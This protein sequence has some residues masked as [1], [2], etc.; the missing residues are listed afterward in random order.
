[1]GWGW[2]Y[3]PYVSVGQRRAKAQRSMDKLRKQG[4][5]VQGVEIEGR[6][7]ARTFWGEAWCSHLESFSDY[8]NRLPR[9]RT[10]VRNGSVCHLEIAAGEVKAIVSGSELYDVKIGIKLLTDEKWRTVK[11]HCSGKIGSLLELLQGRLSTS[12]MTVVTDRARGLFPLPSEI[13]LDCSCPDWAT[14]CKHVAAVLYGVGSRLDQKPELLFLLR[15]VDHEELIEADVSIAASAIGGSKN[16]GRHIADSDLEDLFGIEM[17]S[18]VSST[19]SRRSPKAGVSSAEKPGLRQ[20][21]TSGT[22]GMSVGRKPTSKSQAIVE[23]PSIAKSKSVV[24]PQLMTDSTSKSITK[25]TSAT[26]RA[27]RATKREATVASSKEGA[28]IGQGSSKPAG[29]ANLFSGGQLPTSKAV[30]ELRARLGLSQRELALLIGVS[31]ASVSTWEKKRGRLN[32]HQ[33]TESAL[34]AVGKFTKAQ[35]QRRLAKL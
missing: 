6:K 14:M 34:N 8:A 29:S 19:N 3:R 18:D 32:L 33:R 25:S 26:S 10:Y 15:G 22:K 7:I 23:S 1:M 13:K 11:Q 27:G 24:K 16:G 20:S 35:A 2:S 4:I 31:S 17:C 30:R 12:V 5:H 21:E 28:G 9:G